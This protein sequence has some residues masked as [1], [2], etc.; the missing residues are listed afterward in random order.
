MSGSNF[1]QWKLGCDDE[2]DFL[3]ENN[4]WKLVPRP[5][6]QAVLGGKWAF[7]TKKNVSGQIVK[8]KTR[9]VVQGFRQVHG[10]DFDQTYASVVKSNSYK[11]LLALATQLGW[12]VNHIDFVTAF[13]NGAID[14]HDIFVEQPLAYKVG[15]NLVC[16]LSKALY[17]LKQLP[18]IWYQVLHDFFCTKG[19]SQIEANHSIFVCS[20]RH[21]IIGV[22]VDDLLVVG[23][24]Q[25]EI[26]LL[27]KALTTCFKMTDLGPV[28]HY[29][30]LCITRNLDAGTMFLTQETYVQKILECFGMQNAKGVDTPMAKKDILVYAD[31]SYQA[32]LSTI[33]RY[34]Q[35]V[36]SL[37]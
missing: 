4:T 18:R 23:E 9:W 14:G 33:T 36:G 10:I 28:T 6:T 1:A 5:R 19:F 24:S 30:R 8:Y 22:Y 12:S 17:G 16:K 35:S 29:L 25:K 31:P 11:V 37:M 2:F 26:D 15:I 21:L 34:Q 20:R 13:L 32:D 3:D 27:K 7:N